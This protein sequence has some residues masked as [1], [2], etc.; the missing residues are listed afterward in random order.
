[1]AHHE[2]SHAETTQ[3]VQQTGL[4]VGVE[5]GGGFVE[6]EQLRASERHAEQRPGDRDPP[7]LTGGNALG[8]VT[9]H[10]LGRKVTGSGP[11]KRIGDGGVRRVGKTEPDVVRDRAGEQSGFLA[12]V[13]EAI[14]PVR[15]PSD[16][17]ATA[18]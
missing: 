18:R 11:V 13:R 1:M 4:G 16:R 14:E 3:V 12:D 5:P 7:A 2:R 10:L 8:V 9:D 17:L 15:Q 6:D